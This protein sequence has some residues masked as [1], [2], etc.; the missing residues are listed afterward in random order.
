MQ[1]KSKGKLNIRVAVYGLKIV[2]QNIVALIRDGNPQTLNFIVNNKEIGED[3]WPGQRK[4]ITILYNYD[5]GPLLIAAAKESE[6]L[7]IGNEEFEKSGFL[8]QQTLND[9]LKLS[10]LG[11]TYGP[12]DITSTLKTLI[13]PLGTISFKAD[14]TT[15]GDSWYGV[16]KTLIVILGFGKHATL[17]K[18]FVEREQC[19]IDLKDFSLTS[20]NEMIA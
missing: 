14:N 20:Y 4:S 15:F 10:V 5:D 2:T 17:V 12:A 16:A 6:V 8:S 7:T 11:A 19:Y 9:E 18:M 13:T 3:G 1:I